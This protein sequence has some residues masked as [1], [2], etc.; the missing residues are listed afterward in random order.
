[1]PEA[2]IGHVFA[3]RRLLEL[4]LTHRSVSG[5]ANNERLE[6]LGDSL[7][8]HVIADVLFRRFPAASEGELT[9]AR[10]RLVNADALT[11]VAASL[12]LADHL[13]LG[14]G[15]L[16]SGTW[17]RGSVLADTVEAV[18]GA[19]LLDAG[20][21]KARECM[22]AWYAPLLADLRMEEVI[23]DPKTRLQEYLQ[24]RGLPLPKYEVLETT[25]KAHVQRFRVACT[26]EGATP[27]EAWADSRRIDE[28]IA[29]EG[30]LAQLQPVREKP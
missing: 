13:R 30:V 20:A 15:E 9:R 5:S 23:K 22:L 18:I 19:I 24:G 3:D 7:L 8:G 1:M 28:Q 27:V 12:G 21:E 26:A 4:A 2:A 29:A 10:A 11:R 25:G 6:F 16:K 14:P 17:R